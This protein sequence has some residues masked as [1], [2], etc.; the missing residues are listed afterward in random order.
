MTSHFITNPVTDQ[1]FPSEFKRPMYTLLASTTSPKPVP[2]IPL[3]RRQG[4]ATTFPAG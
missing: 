1:G 3:T 2:S 4:S